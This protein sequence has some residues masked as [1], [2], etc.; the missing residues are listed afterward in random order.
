MPFQKPSAGGSVFECEDG[1]YLLRVDSLEDMPDGEFGPGIKWVLNV[2]DAT[3]KEFL[4]DERGF[5]AELWQF[6]SAKLTPRAKGRKWVEA[7]LGRTLDEEN[8]DGDQIMA[9]LLGKWAIA[10]LAHNDKDRIA[11]VTVSPLKKGAAAPATKDPATRQPVGAGA[12]AR[13]PARQQGPP[14]APPDD[15]LPEGPYDDLP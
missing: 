14:E 13:A 12:P 2:A 7:F 8:D 6:S 5:K 3:T 15:M 10:I 4:L 9:D 1:R 11:I